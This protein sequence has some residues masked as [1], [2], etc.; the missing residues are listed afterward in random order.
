MIKIWF[1]FSFQ[2][3]KVEVI[4]TYLTKF[5]VK[6]PVGRPIYF[7]HNLQV[8]FAVITQCKNWPRITKRSG[9]SWN[10]RNVMSYSRH[11]LLSWPGEKTSHFI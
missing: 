5:Q 4:N 1:P 8:C 3:W 7:E 9:T 10:K 11:G 2:L 6:I